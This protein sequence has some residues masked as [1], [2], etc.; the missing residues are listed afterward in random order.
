MAGKAQNLSDGS[1]QALQALLHSLAPDSKAEGK[2]SPAAVQKLSE[3]LTELVGDNAGEPQNRNEQGQL[4]ND[5]GLPIIDIT[6]PIH[7]SDTPQISLFTDEDVS[8]PVTELP[9][10]EQERRRHERDRILDLLEAE[11]EMELGKKEEFSQEQRKEILHKRKQ[12][13]QDEIAR[14]KAAKEMQRKMGKAL[15]RDMSKEQKTPVQLAQPVEVEEVAPVPRKTV[16]FADADVEVEAPKNREEIPDWGDV[17]PAMLRPNSGRTL[18]SKAQIDSHPMR[19]Q[20]VERIP[21]TPKLEEPQPDSDDESEPPES[22]ANSDAEDR[23]GS[24]EELAEE[25]DMDFARQ[26]REVALEYH[27]K[28]VKMAETTSNAMKSHSHEAPRKTAEESLNQSSRKPA[29][30]HFQ[31]NRLTSSYNTT[32]PSSSKSLGANVLPASS[33]WTL[34]SAIRI[35]KLDEDNHLVGGEAGESGS[36]EEVDTGMQ[37]IMDLLKKG[38]VYNLGPDGNY[39]HTVPPVSESPPTSSTATATTPE[40]PPDLPPPPSRKPPASK[41]KLARAGQRPVAPSRDVSNS[42]T[43]PS[44]AA[45]SSPKLPTQTNVMP[46]SQIANVLSSTVFEKQP[47]SASAFASMIIETPSFPEARRPHHPPVVGRAADKPK[48][49]RFLAERM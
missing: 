37:E 26:Q 4:L 45:R 39:I 11:E 13:A 42:P 36:E 30:S 34:Q 49:S 43:P 24:D 16:K 19:M 41:F 40:S 10:S 18:M 8:V 14:L 31:A 48:V 35:G 23:F 2:L 6:E 21:G 5:E 29:I 7:T 46:S 27:A 33:A 17:V 15:L 38:E 9:S 25:V 3:K 12:A 1:A 32:P 22:P 44:T 20:V 47:P 28:R